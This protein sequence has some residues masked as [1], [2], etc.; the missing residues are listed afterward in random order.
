MKK[1]SSR[2]LTLLLILLFT[3]SVAGCS[4]VNTNTDKKALLVVSFGSSFIENREAAID[5][6][7]SVLADAFSDYDFYRAFT[8]KTIIDIYEKR[9]QV[10]IL[11]VNEAIENIYNDGYGE[12]LVVPTLVINGEEHEEMTE[13]LEPFMDKFEEFTI[14]SPLLSTY[15]DYVTLVEA[16]VE[17]MPE[18]AEDEAIVLMGHG[19]EHEGNSAYGTLD[20]VFKDEGY[21]D[22]FVGTVEGFPTFD[23]VLK[24][25]KKGGYTKVTLMPSMIVAGD[26]AHN[27]MAGDEEDSWKNLLKSEG[28][29]VEF[30]MQGLG[31][32]SAIQQLFVDH[33]NHALTEQ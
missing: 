4:D 17:E 12:V 1:S 8:S 9:D 19:T 3:I 28:Y 24:N 26:H 31:E 15:E 32:L 23:T 7:E 11:S 25:L 5:A 33:A 14:S 10:D 20:Y 13:D 2:I 27:D 22:V 16:L 21:E 29:D 30:I 18:T 6:T